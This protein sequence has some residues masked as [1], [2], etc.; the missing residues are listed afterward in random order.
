[1]FSMYSYGGLLGYIKNS[2]KTI[3]GDEGIFNII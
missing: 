1:M 2:L 3:G